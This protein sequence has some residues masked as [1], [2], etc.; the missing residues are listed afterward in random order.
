MPATLSL[1]ILIEVDILRSDGI[2]LMQE[3]QHPDFGLTQ[4]HLGV[5]NIVGINPGCKSM[6]VL[7]SREMVSLCHH[8]PL[9]SPREQNAVRALALHH[10]A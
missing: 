2:L 1:Q 5:Q 8:W 4:E 3:T 9:Y 6:S 10:I 7:G